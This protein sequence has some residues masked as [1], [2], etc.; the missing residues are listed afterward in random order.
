M[1]TGLSSGEGNELGDF[2]DRAVIPRS[3][4]EA[5]FLTR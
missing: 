4:T 1:R 5:P 2:P 3:I